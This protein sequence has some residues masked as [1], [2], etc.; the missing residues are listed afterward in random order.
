MNEKIQS[1]Y[2][3]SYL[4]LTDKLFYNK[5]LA[6]V[7]YTNNDLGVIKGY[8]KCDIVMFYESHMVNNVILSKPLGSK[9]EDTRLNKKFVQHSIYNIVLY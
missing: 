3:L 9:I 8:L 7:D 1:K 6:L 5:W 2:L 4:F